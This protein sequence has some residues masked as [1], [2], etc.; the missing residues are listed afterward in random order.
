[1]VK[2]T[3][4]SAVEAVPLVANVAPLAPA[5]VSSSSVE[6]KKR[7]AR[8]KQ[9]DI[10]KQAAAQSI[11]LHAKRPATDYI[12]FCQETRAKIM[13]ENPSFTFKEVGQEQGRLWKDLPA[14]AKAV[15]KARQ[16]A[17]KKRYEEEK[18]RVEQSRTQHPDIFDQLDKIQKQRAA[19]AQKKKSS[20]KRA[21]S[22]FIIYCQEQRPILKTTQ[23]TLEFKD[24]GK[25]LGQMWKALSPEAKKKYEDESKADTERYYIAKKAESSASSSEV[26]VEKKKPG[27]KPKTADTVAS[28]STVASTETAAKSA[29][30]SAKVEAAAPVTEAAV[31]EKKKP[32][33]KPK[34]AD[35]TAQA[36]P[37]VAAVSSVPANASVASVPAVPAVA[38]AVPA[39]PAVAS[40]VPV[41]KKKPGRKPKAAVETA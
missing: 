12:Y 37:A 7:A 8:P 26:V 38:A 24:T 14:E 39:V 40:P 10:V 19:R 29:K 15:Y 25:V 20:V 35:T 3:K 23:P 2:Q 30:K 36:V 1:M 11:L 41:E 9:S 34:T 31:V 5:P 18:A 4:K 22:A 33:R 17:D 13:A 21:R 27:R 28:S 6:P 16:E 32:G